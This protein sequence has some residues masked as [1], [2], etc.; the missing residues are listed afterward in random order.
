M[1]NDP[2]ALQAVKESIAR[3]AD[4]P[5]SAVTD[6]QMLSMSGDNGN[7][8][9]LYTIDAP[10]G[11][12]DAVAQ[13]INSSTP[14]AD[15]QILSEQIAAAGL[16]ATY[17]DTKVNSVNATPGPT[18]NPCDTTTA[19]GPTPGPTWRPTPAPNPCDTTP[20]PCDTTGPCDT[21]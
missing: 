15:S 9:V 1:G 12:T 4:V 2:E 3:I 8:K 6:V 11:N 14:E 17:P 21:T 5:V 7:V 19:S 20:N 10:D 16:S 18:P 13:R